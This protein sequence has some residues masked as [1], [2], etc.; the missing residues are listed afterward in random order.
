MISYAKGLK[1]YSFISN[2]RMKLATANKQAIDTKE[3]SKLQM[4]S[5]K[6][7][8]PMTIRKLNMIFK[9]MYVFIVIPLSM[10]N[11]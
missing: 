5:I 2:L 3:L 7:M 9:V 11:R 4:T 8:I 6:N 10:L 1:E